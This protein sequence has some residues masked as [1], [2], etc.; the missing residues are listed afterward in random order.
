MPIWLLRL[1]PLIAGFGGQYGLKRL[2]P[3]IISSKFAPQL[4]KTLAS[5]GMSGGGGLITE[6][7]GF[8]GGMMGMEALLP[9]ED[10][11]NV[12]NDENLSIMENIIRSPQQ[13][14]E[15]QLQFLELLR[16]QDEMGALPDVLENAGISGRLV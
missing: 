15:N 16:Q 7:L 6:L 1:L 9:S 11:S 4:L 8:G 3:G 14:T 10:H 5:K 2:L 12:G 13:M